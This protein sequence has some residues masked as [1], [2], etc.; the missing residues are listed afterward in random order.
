MKKLAIL[1]LCGSLS[2][3]AQKSIALADPGGVDTVTFPS[4]SFS[5]AEIRSIMRVSPKL[6][7]L[8]SFPVINQLEMCNKEDNSYRGCSTEAERK[9]WFEKNARVNI[10]R[11]KSARKAID[12]LPTSLG[13]DRIIEYMKTLQDFYITVNEVQLRYHDESDVSLLEK[14]IEGIDPRLQCAD[15]ILSVA[16]AKSREAAYKV[17][18]FDWYNCMNKQMQKK[19]GPY[20]MNVWLAFLKKSGI[21]ET[22]VPKD[23]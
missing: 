5:E 11:M 21:N 10:D 14:P 3:P 2:V 4:G 17:A 18:S 12:E 9:Q 15:S 6:R 22:Y 7:M 1:L 19:S 16:K 13:L 23:E 8:T 20:P